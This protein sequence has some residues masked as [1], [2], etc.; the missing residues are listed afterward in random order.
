L[1]HGPEKTIKGRD[2]SGE[3]AMS[4]P[5]TKPGPGERVVLTSIPPGLLQGVPEEDQNAIVAIVGKPVL[6]V[7]YDKDGRAELHFD[8]PFDGR[9]G[10]YSHT[11]SIWVAPEFIERHPS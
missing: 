1:K 4:V 8:D 3:I 6:L 9:D 11:H 2:D 10:D 5:D 7:G